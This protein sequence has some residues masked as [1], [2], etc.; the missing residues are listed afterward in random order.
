VFERLDETERT[1]EEIEGQLGDP[2]VL[3]D[4]RRFVEL[5]KRYAELGE[6]VRAYR[7]WRAAQEDLATARQLHHEERSADG[8]ALLDEEIK[9][10]QERIAEP[11]V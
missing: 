5:S 4:Q 1:Y 7:R 10:A 8:R 2:A 9:A 6:V 3:A 11:E